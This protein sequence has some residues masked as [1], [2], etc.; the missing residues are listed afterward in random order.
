MMGRQF[1][2]YGRGPQGHRLVLTLG[3]AS[4]VLLILVGVSTNL[5]S[6][7]IAELGLP[8]PLV[9]GVFLGCAALALLFTAL[10]LR[11]QTAQARRSPERR[12]KERRQALARVTAAMRSA[13]DR[14]LGAV[15]QLPLVTESRPDLVRHPDALPDA[16]I[17]EAGRPKVHE[18][19]LATIFDETG[20]ALLLLGPGGSGKSTLLA[21]LCLDLCE[22]VAPDDATPCVP[23]LVNLTSWAD[24]RRSF[25]QWLADAIVDTYPGIG[26]D[27]AREL[28][29][30]RA[31]A[32]LLDGLDEIPTVRHR[33][34]ALRE[35]DA[36]LAAGSC[37]LAAACRTEDFDGLTTP[38]GIT[39]AVEVLRPTR[40][41]VQ[42]FLTGLGTPAALSVRDVPATDRK[43]WSMMRSVI[44]LGI[45]ARVSSVD[46][47]ADLVSEGTPSE[48]RRHLMAVYVATLLRRR[49][50]RRGGFAH[51]DAHRWLA[52]LATWM[53]RHGQTEFY[54]DRLPVDWIRDV[55]EM[56]KIKPPARDPVLLVFYM[57]A[58]YLL[59]VEGGTIEIAAPTLTFMTSSMAAVTN[60]HIH[61]SSTTEP[62]RLVWRLRWSWAFPALVVV[63]FVTLGAWAAVNAADN[64]VLRVVAYMLL[65]TPVAMFAYA[66][67]PTSAPDQAGLPPG[68][69]LRGSR[70]RAR[71]GA[72]LVGLPLALVLGVPV[73]LG[74]RS[75]TFGLFA[76]AMMASCLMFACSDICGGVPARQYANLFRALRRTGRGP[77]DYLGFLDWAR[78]RLL[79][80][81]NGSALRFPHREIQ[82]HLAET[83]DEGAARVA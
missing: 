44:M 67:T 50:G 47:H 49:G 29:E 1:S 3:L 66:I 21:R 2:S 16:A 45:V 63:P 57:V 83:W 35:I 6:E 23:V 68:M 40:E 82:R 55:S 18:E 9:I 10:Q 54:V 60:A 62:I 37:P 46:A 13:L 71:R 26:P 15:P 42:E 8:R 43:W 32:V 61:H 22:R 19:P 41:R 78:E 48:R 74:A 70:R 52:W 79:L 75:M 59:V 11:Q 30:D 53:T 58:A 25:E 20:Q 12:A 72:L 69:R 77:K 80:E 76:V 65:S 14:A 51:D 73:V 64:G 34:R 17:G 36:F 7:Y 33:R 31:L 4:A 24:E 27:L 5:V 28:I 81:A 39:Y 38:T 56:E